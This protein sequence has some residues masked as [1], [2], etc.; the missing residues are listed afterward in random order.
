MMLAMVGFAAVVLVLLA[1]ASYL[2]W[3]DTFSDAAS[4]PPVAHV[5]GFEA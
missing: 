2:A 3:R 1:G 4:P 5:H